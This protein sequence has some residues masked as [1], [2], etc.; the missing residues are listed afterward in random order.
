[1]IY[2]MTPYSRAQYVGKQRAHPGL[3]SE[4]RRCNGELM[5]FKHGEGSAAELPVHYREKRVAQY[6]ADALSAFW[7]GAV[8]VGGETSS[9]TVALSVLVYRS[10]AAD[11][12][13]CSRSRGICW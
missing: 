6:V 3:A 5:L 1:M 8:G 9:A 2:Q 7:G 4:R 11:L 10:D 13:D 12:S